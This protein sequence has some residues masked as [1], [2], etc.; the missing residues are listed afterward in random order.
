MLRGPRVKS[1]PACTHTHAYTRTRYKLATLHSSFT[2]VF[3]VFFARF[4][5]VA[6][7]YHAHSLSLS[8]SFH[9]FHSFSLSPPCTLFAF[10]FLSFFLPHVHSRKIPRLVKR[11]SP[12]HT[13][14]GKE[15]GA[16]RGGK[17]EKEGKTREP[18]RPAAGEI[19]L[20]ES[21]R[22]AGDRRAAMI[23]FYCA[24]RE[25]ARLFLHRRIRKNGR[26]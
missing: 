18:R 20:N 24:P 13:D 6:P 10:S 26:K 5:L 3:S 12:V 16:E 21:R 2:L 1:A 15:R 17:S 9:W 19:Q 11:R 23:R 25:T 14:S 7:A 8:F 22:R 4:F